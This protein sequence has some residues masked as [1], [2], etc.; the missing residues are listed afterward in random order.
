ML[1]IINITIAIRP[2]A[3]GGESLAAKRYKLPLNAFNFFLSSV[4]VKLNSTPTHA[5]SNL[6]LTVDE[7]KINKLSGVEYE[8]SNI[9]N[10]IQ[11]L[12]RLETF[13]AIVRVKI[14]F[15]MN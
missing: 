4:Q 9:V 11:K 13:A 3:W 1:Q 12:N 8:K 5:Y 6:D 10:E 7:Y 14:L 2:T 15:R